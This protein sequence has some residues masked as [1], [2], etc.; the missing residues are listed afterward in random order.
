MFEFPDFFQIDFAP[1]VERWMSAITNPGRFLR[2]GF[3][4]TDDELIEGL[5]FYFTVTAA[6]LIAYGLITL[7]GKRGS[8][9]IKGRML[10]IGVLGIVFLF[11]TAAISYFPFWLLGGTASFSGTLLAYIYAVGPYGPLL[12]IGQWV[13]VA[14]MPAALRPDA[15][16]P[17]TSQDAVKK[18]AV[19]P[20][21][22]KMTLYIGAVFILGLS[23]WMIVLM[24]RWLAFVHDVGGWRFAAA[25][26]LWCLISVPVSHVYKSMTLLIYD[27]P[28]AASAAVDTIADNT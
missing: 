24:F 16:N 13:L 28:K 23:V 21:V 20:K 8:L 5:R 4:P 3:V 1:L 6:S 22:D 26:I 11:V 19:D 15:L 17:A 18:A 12:S 27:E 10:A 14:G 25:V 2:L 7:F 9:A